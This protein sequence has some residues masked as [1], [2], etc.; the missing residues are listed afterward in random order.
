MKTEKGLDRCTSRV[1]GCFTWRGGIIGEYEFLADH[2][3]AYIEHRTD[4]DGYGPIKGLDEMHT[5]VANA[6]LDNP[7]ACSAPSAF[8]KFEWLAGELLAAGLG[9]CYCPA[10]RTQYD[11]FEFKSGSGWGS[12][13][14]LAANLKCPQGHEIMKLD[15]LMPFC[16]HKVVPG[17][18]L[19]DAYQIP[20]FL[21]KQPT[22][23]RTK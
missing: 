14:W 19:E 21:K 3:A 22:Q 23:R 5:W 20:A 15:L 12:A 10:C 4:R 18:Q 9:R 6:A 1:R 17:Q 8:E 11:G 13:G 2:I 7:A 16:G